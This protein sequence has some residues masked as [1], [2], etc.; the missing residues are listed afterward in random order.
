M[1]ACCSI[2]TSS[3]M[4]KTSSYFII[5]SQLCRLPT[6]SRL[7]ITPVSSVSS[8]SHLFHSTLNHICLYTRLYPLPKCP[9]LV[10]SQPITACIPHN[11]P[12]WTSISFYLHAYPVF[13]RIFSIAA[14][15]TTTTYAPSS[16]VIALTSSVNK[17]SHSIIYLAQ[18]AGFRIFPLYFPGFISFH[19][20]YDI[21]FLTGFA[22][23]SAYVPFQP[24]SEWNS[25]C[26]SDLECYDK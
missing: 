11:F 22:A 26:R 6:S 5:L 17:C 3:H 15:I 9:S 14:C 13:P 20:R 19:P 12:V 7:H 8:L 10:L 23:V 16:Q 2:S 21:H 25:W 18:L 24:W 1:H 4:N